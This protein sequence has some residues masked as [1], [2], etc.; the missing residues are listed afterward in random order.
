MQTVFTFYYLTNPQEVLSRVIISSDY[1]ARLL[2][3]V[4]VLQR[5]SNLNKKADHSNGCDNCNDR[6]SETLV[7]PR[8]LW[9]ASVLAS[10]RYIKNS[11]RNYKQSERNGGNKRKASNQPDI[12]K[13]TLAAVG[14]KKHD[15]GGM[16]L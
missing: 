5:R 16:G 4:I 3:S 1:Y 13:S 9:S 7:R 14:S 10:L 15:L 12:T 2:A 6:V 11:L 8:G